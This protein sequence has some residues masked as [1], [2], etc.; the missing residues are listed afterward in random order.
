VIARRSAQSAFVVTVEN[1]RKTRHVSRPQVTAADW[2]DK[3]VSDQ[4]I[5]V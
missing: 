1:V 2:R 3:K 4:G 5:G